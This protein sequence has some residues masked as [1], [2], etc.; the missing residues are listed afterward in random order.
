VRSERLVAEICEVVLGVK[1]IDVNQNLF[2]LGANS[3]LAM[4][5]V[6]RLSGAFGVDVPIS[7]VFDRPTIAEIAT[8]FRA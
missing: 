6:N 2:D 4:M 8:F 7:L 3:L 5:I 1:Q